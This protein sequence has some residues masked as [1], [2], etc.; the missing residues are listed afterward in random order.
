[1]T[2]R[3]AA[4]AYYDSYNSKQMGAVLELIAEDCVYEDLIYQD[5]FVG[6]A[7]IAAYFRKIEALVPPDIKFCVEDITEGDPRRCGVRWHVEIADDSGRATEFPFSRGV[8]FY[9]VND[10]GQIVFARDIVEP[11]I[12]PGAAALSGISVVAPLVRKLGP[13]AN[14]A[15]LKTLPL[16]SG[17]MW[18]FYAGYLGYVMLSTAAPGV[19]AWQVS[20]EALQAVLHESYNYFYVNIGLAQLGLNPVPCIAEHPVSEAMFNAVNAWSLMW[21]PVMLADPLGRRVKSKLP[22]WVGTQFLTNVFFPIYLAKRL[23]PESPEAAA[24]AQGAGSEAAPARLPG[25]APIVG[26]VAA[27]VGVVS[28]GWALFARPEAGDLPARWE[29]FT[30]LLATSRVDWAFGVDACLYAV[31]QAWLLGAVGAAPAYRFVPFFG[32][33]AWLM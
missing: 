32:L 19:P 31:W 8:S 4:L 12:K 3:E 30:T 2:A 18:A 16:A 23:A 29:Y 27:T 22:I 7:A 9:E 26:A 21:W 15:V 28:I 14:P 17:A 10:L 5:P 33:A 20:P 11:A 6:R 13:N 25:C 24:A 1:R